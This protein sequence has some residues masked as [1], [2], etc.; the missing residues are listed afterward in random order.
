[1]SF[2]LKTLKKSI[3]DG[4]GNMRFDYGSWQRRYL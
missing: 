2:I 1:M 3:I 4:G